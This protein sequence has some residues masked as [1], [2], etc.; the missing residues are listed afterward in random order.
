MLYV[1]QTLACDI[2]GKEIARLDQAVTQGTALQMVQ[3]GP[4]GVTAWNDVCGEC[5]G[6][7]HKALWALKTS[8]GGSDE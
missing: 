6:P 4:S 8:K 5:T 2:C 1:T 3:R 7:L